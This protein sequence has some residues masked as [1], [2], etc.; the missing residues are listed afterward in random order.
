MPVEWFYVKDGADL[1]NH[2]VTYMKIMEANYYQDKL[3]FDLAK[4]Y[5]EN[6]LDK[7]PNIINLYENE[8]KCELL[9]Y[10]ILNGNIE[11]VKELYT[12]GLRN[13]IKLTNCYI[14]RKRLMYV[15]N[16]LV[17]KDEKKADKVLEEFEKVKKSYPIKG[18]I[19]SEEEIMNFIL[20]NVR[21]G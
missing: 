16:L 4:E 14:S 18:E 19:E 7:A 17:L 13:Y 1:S 3:N 2:M 10:E 12:K 5:Y 15:Y 9:F 11:K 21:V 8:I 20:D 6:I